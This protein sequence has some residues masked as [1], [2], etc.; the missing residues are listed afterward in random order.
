[1]SVC[2]KVEFLLIFTFFINFFMKTV[3]KSIIYCHT[4]P[5]NRL[6]TYIG[7]SLCQAYLS[8]FLT[9]VSLKI[10]SFRP[11]LNRNC[12][13][14]SASLS[15][16]GDKSPVHELRVMGGSCWG[17]CHSWCKCNILC[18]TSCTEISLFMGKNNQ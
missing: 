14:S 10:F 1:M 3:I 13:F 11:M 12:W 8:S 17:T 6:L 15:S 18:L 5:L 2:E 7:K 4:M 16:V 9:W